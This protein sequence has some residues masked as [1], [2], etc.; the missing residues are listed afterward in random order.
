MS[1]IVSQRILSTVAAREVD[2]EAPPHL[3][4]A[5]MASLGDSAAPAPVHPDAAWPTRELTLANPRVAVA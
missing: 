5:A 4:I 2:A 1:A 3:F